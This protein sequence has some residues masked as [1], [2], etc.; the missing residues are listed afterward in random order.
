[1]DYSPDL[2]A[3]NGAAFNHYAEL[4]CLSNF[5][6]LRGASHAEELILQADKLGYQALAITDECSVA[7]IVRAYSAIKEHQLNIKL[8]V[9]SEFL[10]VNQQ[11]IVVLCPDRLAYAELCQLITL[12]RRRCQKGYYQLALDDLKPLCHCLLLWLP[13]AMTENSEIND[14]DIDIR[15][16]ITFLGDKTLKQHTNLPGVNGGNF[17]TITNH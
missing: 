14:S 16:F 15:W 2:S 7:G 4:H 13:R 3:S 1:M 10:L 11:K 6:F 9:G 8:I 12:A 5:S 17:Q